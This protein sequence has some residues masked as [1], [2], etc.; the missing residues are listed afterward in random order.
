MAGKT[1]DPVLLLP[2]GL[3]KLDARRKSVLVDD[4]KALCKAFLSSEYYRKEVAPFHPET[5]GAFFLP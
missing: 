1:E 4:G 2:E 5:E 3:Q